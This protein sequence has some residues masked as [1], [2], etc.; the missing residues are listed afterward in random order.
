MRGAAAVL[1][2]VGLA[3]VS[4]GAQERGG[5]YGGYGDR[6][7]RVPPGHLPPAGECRVWYDDRPAG[8]QPPPTSCHNA[9][10]V[11]SRDRYARVIYGS[12]RD[13]RDD[14]RWDDRDARRDRPQVSA[15]RAFGLF[16]SG[17]LSVRSPVPLSGSTAERTR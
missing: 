8:H 5:R 16:I 12:D 10:R 6:P 1:V 13:R 14:G 4:V 17:S 11:A 2:V 15:A 3:S 9:E 7:Q